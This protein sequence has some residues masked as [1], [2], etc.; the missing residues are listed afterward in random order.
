MLE[1]LTKNPNH[2]FTYVEQSF[3]Q[4]WWSEADDA[5]K[6]MARNLVKNGQLELNLGGWVMHDE[7]CTDYEGM[8]HQMALGTKYVKEQFGIRPKVGWHIDP[9]GHSSQ[10]ARLM[11]QMGFDAFGINRIDYLD[12]QRRRE[13]QSLETIWRGSTSLN[14]DSDVFVFNFWD[15]YYTPPQIKFNTWYKPRNISIDDY[16]AALHPKLRGI[17]W[18]IPKIADEFVPIC[19]EKATLYILYYYYLNSYNNGGNVLIPFG[20]DFSFTTA[21]SCFDPMDELI[22]YVNSNYEKYHIKFR[23]STFGEYINI[24]HKN[25]TETKKW[26]LFK[27][28][29]FPYAD[30]ITAYWGGYYT[31]RPFKKGLIRDAYNVLRSSELLFSDSIVNGKIKAGNASQNVYDNIMKLRQNQGLSLHH[32]AI[33]GTEKQHVNDDYISFLINLF[34]FVF[35]IKCM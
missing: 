12:K 28:D 14:E 35:L 5:S 17:G 4:R 33:T 31:S 25:N 10:N 23:Y 13:T 26:P 32:D 9:F 2:K 27:G 34:V 8:I 21:N 11:S 15:H 6:E 24:V 20:A 18:D 29:F 16:W 1:S 22:E 30:K 19:K 7:A 3:F